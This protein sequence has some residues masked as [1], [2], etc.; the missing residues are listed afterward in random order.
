VE[1]GYGE[2]FESSHPGL[3]ADASAE[4]EETQG[5]D[6]ISLQEDDIEMLDFPASNDLE[7]SI[8]LQEDSTSP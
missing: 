7:G 5:L 2:E 3:Q 8:Y 6:G 1:Q 4:E